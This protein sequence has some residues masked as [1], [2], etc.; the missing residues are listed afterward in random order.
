MKEVVFLIDTSVSMNTLDRE[1]E[2]ITII[3]QAAERLQENCRVGMV[4][5][6]TELQAVVPLGAEME[7]LSQQL[8]TIQY[9]GYTNA[10]AGLEQA[11]QM[12][13]QGKEG[14]EDGTASEVTEKYI[15]MLSDGEIDMPQKKEREL[16]RQTYVDAAIQAKEEGI[17]I[18][19]AAM[20]NELNDP[21]LHIFDGAGITDGAIYWAG[22][23][24]SLEATIGQ[25]IEERVRPE[26]V[27][28]EPETELY[29]LTI[30]P[31]P[32][33]APAPEPL[34]YRPLCVILGL[35]AVA[36]AVI[37]LYCS[38]K[39]RTDVVY[40]PQPHMDYPKSARQIQSDRL[41]SYS[42]KM[43]IYV[44]KTADEQD[45]PPQT[46]RLFGRS[47]EWLS[48]TKVLETCGIH[49]DRAK[50]DGIQFFPGQDHSLI[51]TDRSSSC[52][53][54]RGMEVLRKGIEYPVSYNAKITVAFDKA[55]EIEIHY[56]SLKPS[57]LVNG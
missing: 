44:V 55:T 36:I 52:S 53:V 5:Y 17:R 4:A 9:Y 28:T 23:H 49:M 18:Y 25:M 40:V 35:L 39:R 3:R 54:F 19:I 13:G 46:Y 48:L 15:I 22:Q 26:E 16:S 41:P 42:G 10:G 7:E 43:N 51:V 24:E 11:V 47:A 29:A 45:I 21:K 6:N 27:R 14:Q 50:T 8:E 33:A 2:V 37:A 57:E 56:K 31:I 12:F 38:R 34:D 20:G 32:E 30:A 1:R